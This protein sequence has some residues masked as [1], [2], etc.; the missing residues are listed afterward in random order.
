MTTQNAIH[1]DFKHVMSC[2]MGSL[3]ALIHICLL[4]VWCDQTQN[5]FETDIWFFCL[6]WS[7]HSAI[8]HR[9]GITT[10]IWQLSRHAKLATML[11]QKLFWHQLLLLSFKILCYFAHCIVKFLIE[12]VLHSVFLHWPSSLKALAWAVD[13][14]FSAQALPPASS[15]PY[16]VSSGQIYAFHLTFFFKH[17]FTFTYKFTFTFTH[18]FIFTFTCKFTFTL[19]HTSLPLLSHKSIISL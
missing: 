15:L 14:N 2:L 3:R 8:P 4:F 17:K 5:N 16:C 10:R 1:V 12:K 6:F 18:K 7:Q 11:L 13:Q 19:S 9:M